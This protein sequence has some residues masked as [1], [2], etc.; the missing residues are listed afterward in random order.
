MPTGIAIAAIM[1]TT[2]IDLLF[3]DELYEGII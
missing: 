1:I 3:M 2:I